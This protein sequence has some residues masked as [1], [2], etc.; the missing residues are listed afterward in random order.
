[1]EGASKHVA[2][3]GMLFFFVV[4]VT[5]KERVLGRRATCIERGASPIFVDHL[6]LS[7]RSTTVGSAVVEYPTQP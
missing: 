5:V 2:G 7:N 3:V 4:A 1:M 6:T